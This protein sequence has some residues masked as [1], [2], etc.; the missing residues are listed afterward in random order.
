MICLATTKRLPKP[1]KTQTAVVKL[2]RYAIN[3][4][5]TTDE[6]CLYVDSINCSVV[7][8][9]EQFKVVRDR[10]DKN[11]G[12]YAYHF[13]Q[14]FKPGETSPAEAH[15]CGIELAQALFGS[16][17]YQVVVCTHLDQAHLHN[18][19][20]VNSVNLLDGKKLQTDHDFIRRMREENDR[21]CRAHNLSVVE[22]PENKGKSYAEWIID[23]NGGFTWRGMIREDID[24]LIPCVS[25]LKGL[26]DELS[27]CGYTVYHRGKYISLSPPG[28]N[29]HFRLYKLG[30]GYSE[31]DITE[32]ILY[33]GRRI[34]KQPEIKPIRI[35]VKTYRVKTKYPLKAKGGFRGLY[36]VYLYRLRNL[37][38]ASTQ[39]QRKMPVQVRRDTNL[40]RE[41]AEDANLLFDNQIDSVDQL[42]EFYYTLDEQRKGLYAKR[43]TLREALGMCDTVETAKT[44]QS[45]IVA[46]NSLL[47]RVNRQM[48]SCERIYERSA[49][50]KKANQQASIIQKGMIQKSQ[51]E[52][53]QPFTTD[54]EKN[55]RNDENV[56]RS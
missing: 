8:T 16:C 34:V 10:W 53:S 32:R 47:Q 28:T 42:A 4:E 24:A 15:Q 25:T 18:H 26:L 13:E 2:I 27:Q 12:N 36:Y 5:K 33:T 6:K 54:S 55:E 49:R 48:K 29:A 7:G 43:L 1:P 14:S 31:E 56:S 3:P 39:M 20:V 37:L 51:N 19:F 17:G 45:Q 40:F 30:K 50:T 38:G 9:A 35:Q 46:I 22:S 44:L 41:F 52:S 21:I 11:S 23:K